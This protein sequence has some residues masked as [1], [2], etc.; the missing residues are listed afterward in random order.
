MAA[1]CSLR[2]IEDNCS[3]ATFSLL[4]TND[5]AYRLRIELDYLTDNVGFKAYLLSG[6]SRTIIKGSEELDDEGDYL[7]V[8]STK[9]RKIKSLPFTLKLFFIKARFIYGIHFA[10]IRSHRKIIKD[11]IYRMVENGFSSIDEY[12]INSVH[13]KYTDF[14]LNRSIYKDKET[15]KL[16]NTYNG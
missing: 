10:E 15:D 1:R 7:E 3:I 12:G 14:D 13:P 11:T 2:I 4:S 9:R 16:L 5:I 8:F 6:T